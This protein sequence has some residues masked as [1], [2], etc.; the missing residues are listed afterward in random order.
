[1][2]WRQKYLVGFSLAAFIAAALLFALVT[3]FLWVE[4]V[5]IEEARVA[6][7]AETLGQRTEQVIVDAR[8]MLDQFNRYPKPACSP[9]HV[10]AMQEAA[11]A[12]PY[13]RAIG[14]WRAAKRICG[15]GFIQAIELKPSQ[16]D[17]VY[18][19][20]VI[21]WWPSP[22]TEVGGVRLF[23]M[24]YG[25]HDIAVDPRMLLETSTVQEW[26]AGLWVENLPLSSTPWNTELPAPDTLPIG[27]T[28][29]HQNDRVVSRF[30]LGTIFPIDVVAIEPIG[31][32]WDRYAPMLGIATGVG[33]T[34]LIVWVYFVLRYSRHRLSL[35]TELKEALETGQVQVHYQP[36]VKL[37]SGRCVGAEALARWTRED[38]EIVNPDVFLPIAEEAG[39]VP[40]ITQVVL[41]ATLR[42]LGQLLRKS[43][44]AININLAPEDLTSET[45]GPEL[46]ESC[47]AAG[48]GPEKIK[49][50]ITERA[51]VDS[52]SSRNIISDFRKRGHQV[53]IDDFGTGYS[54]LSYLE[55]FEI[56]TLKID[57][58]F[59]DAIG[60]DAVTSH[61]IGH[62]IDLSK[63]LRLETVAEG[64][65]TVPQMRWLREQGVE[66][67][68]GFLFSQPLPASEFRHYFE[69]Q[70]DSKVQAIRQRPA[71]KVA[72]RY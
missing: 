18:D 25:K 39:L 14:Y 27:L 24:R 56:D 62:V 37:S 59:V 45:F 68:Q 49:L 65:R 21:A 7:L 34:I 31:L 54:S 67:G 29:D 46:A 66:L 20:G 30:S 53:A 6:D 55:S 19:S 16:A 57:K 44:I 4:S 9:D 3:W 5:R 28:V 42:D 35:S 32:F 23:L 15:V 36:I 61:V 1:M 48:V 13:I 17:R 10:K 47:E 22:Q 51:I 33:L 58:S 40:R 52:G 38:G 64:I 60:R 8:D 2:F 41:K 72:S 50:E 11:I 70:I 71:K 63:S 26:Q 12:R 69:A 43:N